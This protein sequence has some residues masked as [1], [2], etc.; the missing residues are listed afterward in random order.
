[1]FIL[2]RLFVT[3]GF[4]NLT[5]LVFEYATVAWIQMGNRQLWVCECVHV[6]MIG[7]IIFLFYCNRWHIR[8]VMKIRLHK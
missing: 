7:V 8:A 1:M 4:H 5:E 3:R 6:K 2:L